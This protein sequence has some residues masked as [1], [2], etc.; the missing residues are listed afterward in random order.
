M[1]LKDKIAVITGGGQ[2]IGRGLARLFAREGARVVIAARTTAK[3][4]QVK[5]EIE[6]EGGDVLA[7][8][9]DVG[10]QEEVERLMGAT[11]A[12]FGGLDV[13]V[14]N[15][16]VGLQMPVDDVDME[17]YERLM[18]TNLKGMYLGC[19][20]G[21][22]LLKERGKGSIINISSVHG[23]DGSPGNSVYA[24]TKG[25]I[26]GC[27]RALAGELAPFHIRVNA[28]SPGA[29]LINDPEERLL[30]RIKTEHHSEFLQ[31]FGAVI[32]PLHY[33]F[34]PLQRIGLPEDIAYCALYLAADESRFVTGQ[35][36]VVDGG[37]TTYLSPFARDASQQQMEETQQQMEEW[38]AAH[39]EEG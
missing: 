36:I 29:I 3:L 18:D 7:V 21:V 8:P 25:G 33:Y 1:R 4:E 19:R 13:L 37:L 26:I 16:G 6:A 20:F 14:N 30:G 9:T 11:R 38:I 22:P 2:G 17:K 34:Q 39:A 27:T 32:D 12:H 31:R 10:R 35:N 23:V 15:A 28:I 5:T 24:A